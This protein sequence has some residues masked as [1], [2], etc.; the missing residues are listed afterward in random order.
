MLSDIFIIP[1]FFLCALPIPTPMILSHLTLNETLIFK[2][3]VVNVTP[4]KGTQHH[5]IFP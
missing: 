5:I 4:L 2:H 3:F 1:P